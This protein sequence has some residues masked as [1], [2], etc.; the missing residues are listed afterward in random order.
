[1]SAGKVLL[2]G[3]LGMCFTVPLRG[4]EVQKQKIAREYRMDSLLVTGKRTERSGEVSVGTRISTLSVKVMEENKTKSLSELLSDHSMTYIKGLGQGAMATSS[5]RGTSANHTQVN[6]N[7]ININPKMSGSFDFSQIPV[8]FTDQVSLFHG[9]SH[10]KGGTGALGGSINLENQ[11]RWHDSTRLKCLLETGSYATHT[12]AVMARILRKKALYQ[13]RVYHQRSENNFKYLNKVLSKDPFYER[14]EEAAYRLSGIMQE[15]YFR[16]DEHTH[17]SANLWVQYGT[18]EL[19]QPIIV[20]VV[21]H[22]KQKEA[23]VKYLMEYGYG[24]E[25]HTVLVKMAYTLDFLDYTKW[26]DGDYLHD[27]TRSLNRS[28]ALH[29]IGDYTCRALSGFKCNVSTRYIRDWVIASNYSQQE[30][31]RNVLVVQSNAA[32]RVAPR[33]ELSGQM[34]GE[35][36]DARFAPTFSAAFDWEAMRSLHLKGSAAYNYRFPSLNDLYWL[37]GGNANLNPESGFSYDLTARWTPRLGDNHLFTSE[38][39]YY[40]MLIDDWIMWLPT[41]NWYWEPRNVQ[42]VL[43]HGLEFSTHW[44]VNLSSRWK[45]ELGV[46]YTYS[47]SMNRERN[48]EEDATYGKQLPYVPKHK[49][50]AR[51]SVNYRELSFSYKVNYTGVRYT[52]QDESYQTNPYTIHHVELSYPFTI[53]KRYKLTPKVRVD[54]LFNAYYESTQYYPMP[55]RNI[56]FGVMFAL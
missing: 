6:W 33:L 18:R 39:S 10:L 48:F 13:T 53:C 19:P 38:A 7:G 1:M 21:E 11:P 54:N 55:L 44:S 12:G 25:R 5:L 20:N 51:L 52:S 2:I 15:A 34:M 50:N 42:K 14:R 9:G 23:G 43:S 37:P 56:S 31:S 27:P 49:A 24:A 8:F 41:Q 36:N 46:N 3:F 22:E 45:G 35:V 16:P 26:F 4:Q 40:V 47:R 29:F 32:W 30:V 28:H 17:F